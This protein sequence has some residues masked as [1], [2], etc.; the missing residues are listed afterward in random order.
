MAHYAYQNKSNRYTVYLPADLASAPIRIVFGSSWLTFSLQAAKGSGA[1]A[2]GVA[3][4]RNALPGV[5]VVVEAKADTL[6]ESLVLQGPAAPSQFTYELQM[7]P[8]MKLNP[9]GA[10]LS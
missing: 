4:Y 6:E 8:G 10:G 9:A 2:G 3:S 5:A 7:G 1:I